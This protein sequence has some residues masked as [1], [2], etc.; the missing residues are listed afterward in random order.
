M[1]INDIGKPCPYC[2]RELTE[3][4]FYVKKKIKSD[5]ARASTEKAKANGTKMGPPTTFNLS[6]AIALR[7]QYKTHVAIGRILG[8]SRHTIGQYFRRH[9]IK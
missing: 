8:V 7:S 3:K 9:G 6:E 4:V 2:K 1:K 5:N